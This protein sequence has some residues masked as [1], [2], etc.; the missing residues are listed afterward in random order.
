MMRRFCRY[1]A[2]VFHLPA[3]ISRLRDTRRRPQYSAQ[4]I[5]ETVMTLL[6]TGRGSL[7]SIE[8]DRLGARSMIRKSATGPPSDDTL[9]RVFDCLD[10]AGVLQMLVAINHQSKRNKALPLWLNLRFAAVDGHEFFSSR[11][12]HCEEC[13]QRTIKVDGEEVV[14]YYHQ[15]VVCHLTGYPSAMPLDV[16]M[17]RPGEG[18]VAAARRLLERVFQRYPRFFDVVLGD[19]LYCEAGFF[20][21]CLEHGKA[22]VAVLKGDDR[23]LKRDAEL[24]FSQMAPQIWTT[25][26]REV[27]AWD[28]DGFRT[29]TGVEH[30]IRV[31]HT[32]EEWTERTHVNGNAV[33]KQR[34]SDW[35]WAATIPM[36]QLPSEQMWKAGHSRWDIEN[37]DFNT[38]SRHW[39]LDHCF[40][41]TP[42]AIVNFVRTIFIVHILLQAF[43]Q[44][45]LKPARRLG[46][47]LIALARQLYAAWVEGGRM[48]E[49]PEMGPSP[50]TS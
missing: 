11:K 17:I 13:L 20:N 6:V 5:W 44:R 45:N 26:G 41:H 40:K 16:E 8:A 42:R 49:W 2:K 31:L 34:C 25:K 9:G 36:L 18:E 7:H 27:Q 24:R 37:D 47:T 43:F 46:V 14:E 15:G 19:A 30:A 35:W 28:L 32:H 39:F 1:I 3:L 22:V 33:V 4:F 12:R 23:Q 29:M 48:L 38:L 10:P 21:F 50:D